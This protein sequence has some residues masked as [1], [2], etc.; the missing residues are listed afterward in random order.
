MSQFFG[1][2]EQK[3]RIAHYCDYC[4]DW[5]EPGDVYRRVLWRVNPFLHA[6]KE[7]VYPPCQP[8]EEEYEREEVS[9]SVPVA[10]AVELVEVVKIS[11]NGDPITTTETRL[12]P[13]TLD[14]SLPPPNVLDEEIPF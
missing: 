10:I 9:L 12:T 1:E 14:D 3:A 6:M 5:I 11:I 7:H 8:H 2:S 4:H 13:V